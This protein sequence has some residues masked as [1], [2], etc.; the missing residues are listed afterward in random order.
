MSWVTDYDG[1]AQDNSFT[2]GGD[3][4]GYDYHSMVGSDTAF[5]IDAPDCFRIPGV[6]S[7][8]RDGN[9]SF[10]VVRGREALPR[11]PN[12]MDLVGSGGHVIRKSTWE[13][14]SKDSAISCDAPE[15]F[16]KPY[17]PVSRH[18]CSGNHFTFSDQSKQWKTPYAVPETYMT[19]QGVQGHNIKKAI[20]ESW[21]Q[22][23]HDHFG[24]TG[25]SYWTERARPT[26]GTDAR[27]N[28]PCSR[29]SE[30]S[31][32]RPKTTVATSSQPHVLASSMP[33]R[34]RPISHPSGNVRRPTPVQEDGRN[35]D[36]QGSSALHAS[37]SMQNLRVQDD[38]RLKLDMTLRQAGL[39]AQSTSSAKFQ[40]SLLNR[41]R[42]KARQGPPAHGAGIPAGGMQHTWERSDSKH[43]HAGAERCHNG[44]TTPAGMT[45]DCDV[46]RSVADILRS[47]TPQA[48]GRR[49]VTAGASAPLVV[50][51]RQH[52]DKSLGNRLDHL[53][54]QRRAKESSV[55]TGQAAG[56]G[57]TNPA[58]WRS[59]SNPRLKTSLGYQTK[60]Q[61][62]ASLSQQGGGNLQKPP[63][64]PMM[65]AGGRA[66]RADL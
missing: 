44:R 34:A 48:D 25:Q 5:S 64:S 41:Q 42:E 49:P 57:A 45:N 39:K 17:V 28:T 56:M 15:V 61:F 9:G 37:S 24:D 1:H 3:G 2:D 13:N 36:Q 55:H 32:V 22:T 16:K 47:P 53:E 40:D 8:D 21:Q 18:M 63:P 26:T 38:L 31:V 23:Y 10:R 43:L 54:G 65:S 30:R 62:A 66:T 29:S 6:S 60:M 52:P 7:F 58:R 12:P 11:T 59:T 19:R 20:T 27:V 35:N 4:G 50:D 33:G 46:G 14:Q 51:L